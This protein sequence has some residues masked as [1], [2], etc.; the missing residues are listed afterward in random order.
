VREE[1]SV[2]VYR[3]IQEAMTNIGKHADAQRASITLERCPH[4][5]QF[6]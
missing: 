1:L 5:R 3:V 2:T 4:R 6:A